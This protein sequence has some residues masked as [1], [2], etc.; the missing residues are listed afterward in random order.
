M[1]YEDGMG[2]AT[3]SVM[4]ASCFLSSFS[5]RIQR[6]RRDWPKL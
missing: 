1:R 2:V 5:D 4:H 6:L 3:R